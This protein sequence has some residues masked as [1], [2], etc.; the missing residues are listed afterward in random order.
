MRREDGYI[1]YYSGVLADHGLEGLEKVET[2]WAVETGAVKASF[3]VLPLER[4][5]ETRDLA[6]ISE[7]DILGDR[8]VRAGKRRKT[9]ENVLR[10]VAVNGRAVPA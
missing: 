6:V 5:F 7:Q 9:V 8:L 2:A 3:A 4:G 1:V 10:D